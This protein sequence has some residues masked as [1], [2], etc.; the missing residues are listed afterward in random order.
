MLIQATF[1]ASEKST[2]IVTAEFFDE[3]GVAMIPSSIKW[4]LTD[5]NG[6]VINSR[7]EIVIAPP[8]QSITIVLFGADLALGDNDLGE[9]A[10]LIEATYTS[11]LGAGLPLNEELDFKIGDLVG[12]E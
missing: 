12:V 2:Y 8:T 9:R 1:D 6:N 11:T 3:N 4:T 5:M 7:H 10:L